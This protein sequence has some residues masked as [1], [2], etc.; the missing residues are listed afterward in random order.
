[1]S[2]EHQPNEDSAIWDEIMRSPLDPD[3][4]EERRYSSWILPVALCAVIGYLLGSALTNS[5]AN[6]ESAA[7]PNST[8]STSTNAPPPPNPIFPD[9]YSD[10]GSVGIKP[11]A[12]YSNNGS[13]YIVVNS[14]ARSDLDRTETD[15]FHV[16]EWTLAGD[17]VDIIANR[18]IESQLSP[19]V[20]LV[21]FPDVGALP[22][23]GPELLAREATEMVVRSGCQGCE[24]ISV[25][26][27][28]G[29]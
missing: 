21:E 26:M 28:E 9:G 5:T 10:T 18:T 13:L 19:G 2:D 14:A 20:R 17:G 4:D 3:P 1:M 23:S 22:I 6:T 11:L 25:H 12:A 15:E 24:A 8:T 27:A 16:A 29:E 7:L